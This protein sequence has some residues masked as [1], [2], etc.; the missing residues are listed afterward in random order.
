MNTHLFF[1]PYAPHI[2]TMHTAAIL[3][4]A[5]ALVQ[6]Q[7]QLQAEKMQQGEQEQDKQR[8]PALL[9]CGDLNSDLNDG[10]PGRLLTHRRICNLLSIPYTVEGSLHGGKS[11]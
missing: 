1:H 10:I 5:W 8:Q 7:Q 2:R 6:Q 4:E 11:E 9:F 3:E